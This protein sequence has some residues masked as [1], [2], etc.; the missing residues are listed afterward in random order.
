MNF[1]CWYRASHL[2]NIYLSIL[3]Q[4]HWWIQI[5]G[6][7][8]VTQSFTCMLPNVNNILKSQTIYKDYCAL[9]AISCSKLTIEALELGVTY[10]HS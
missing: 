4:C 2:T 8:Q 3:K 10:V 6:K 7:V 1:D 9:S 5:F